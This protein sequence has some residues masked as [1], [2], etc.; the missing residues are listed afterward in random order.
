VA[1]GS[2]AERRSGREWTYGD[3][4]DGRCSSDY[5]A[6]GWADVS[7]GIGDGYD[8]VFLLGICDGI[9]RHIGAAPEVDF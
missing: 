3:G 9:E 2:F 6:I 4:N 1:S 7:S 8:A 5:G